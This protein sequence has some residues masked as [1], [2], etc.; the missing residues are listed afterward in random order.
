MT[1]SARPAVDAGTLTALL[2][3]AT[4]RLADRPAVSDDRRTLTYAELDRRSDV[5]ADT[6]RGHG[7]GE[8][9]RVGL[10]LEPSVDVFVAALGIAKAGADHIVVDTRLP[11]DRRA[12]LL[13]D[14]GVK[15]VVTRPERQEPL[16]ALG[17]GVIPFPAEPAATTAA[18]PGSDPGAA[19][20]IPAT[21]HTERDLQRLLE[22]LAQHRERQRNHLPPATETERHLARLWEAL[23]GIE[24]IGGN[25]D[26]FRL[27]GH[28]LLAFRMQSRIKRELGV[29]LEY[30]TVLAHPVLSA[31]AAEIDAARDELDFL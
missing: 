4:A 14:G 5:L 31:L 28:S 12:P 3:A 8:E 18:R 20:G 27:G 15:L 6:L 23:L 19:P 11:D 13:A 16:H 30:R 25:D 21:D 29:V 7:V 2:T 10:H 1:A 24:D 26:F 9:H 22:L 17:L